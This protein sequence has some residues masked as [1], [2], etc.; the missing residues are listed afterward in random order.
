MFY[1]KFCFLEQ[2]RIQRKNQEKKLQKY[3]KQKK[4]LLQLPN[5]LDQAEQTLFINIRLYIFN[6]LISLIKYN[7]NLSKVVRSIK[8]DL[9]KIFFNNF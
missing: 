4:K 3:Q 7:S 2:S 5:L 6:I 9:K 8:Y 1:L